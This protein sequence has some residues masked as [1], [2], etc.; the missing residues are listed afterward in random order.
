MAESEEFAEA[1]ISPPQFELEQSS[2]YSS[3]LLHSKSEIRA[4]LRSLIQKRVM[5]TVYFD[6]GYSFFLTSLIAL[7]PDDTGLILDIGSNEEMNRKALLAKKLIFTTLVD[8]VKIQFSLNNLDITES[9]GRPAFLAALPETVLRL[10]RREY[11]R[12]STPIANPVRLSST[13]QRTD[14]S[15]MAV[16][17]PLL[18]V[19]GGGVGLM[20]SLDQAELLH[21]GTLLVE[22]KIA[23][24]DEGVLVTDLSVRNLFDVSTRSGLRYVRVGCEYIGLPSPRLSMVQR[25]ITRVER[26][27]KARLS[28]MV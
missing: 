25:Y 18:D 8:K 20:A 26:E 16:E 13:L 23:L 1:R 12:L 7:T 9:D 22:C 4:V 15:V 21:R 5:I 28:G 19:S 17:F 11:F 24:P 27:R 6:H 3:Y 2:D 10:Q 14:G